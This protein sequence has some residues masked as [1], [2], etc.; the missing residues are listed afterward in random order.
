MA[1]HSISDL[2]AQIAY[3]KHQKQEQEIAIKERFSSPMAIFDTVFSSAKSSGITSALFNPDE[4]IGLVSRFVLP[5]LLNKTIFRGSNF[6]VKT[7][8]ALV[9]QQ[10]SGLINK[11][12]ITS[13]W[14]NIRALIAKVSPKKKPANYSM[15]PYGEG[16]LD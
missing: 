16:I 10:A 3:L 13:T 8:V 15:P 9:S 11:D 12:T 1:I 4:L 6:I 5:L 2:R 7:L 14:D